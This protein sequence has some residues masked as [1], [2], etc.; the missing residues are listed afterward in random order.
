[1]SAKRRA[2]ARRR[3]LAWATGVL[4]VALWLGL[5]LALVGIITIQSATRPVEATKPVS[6]EVRA[7]DTALT[8]PV[9]LALDWSSPSPL[10]APTWSGVVQAVMVKSGQKVEN[11]TPLARIDG[12]ERRL[13]LTPAPF[14]LPV[15]YGDR[16]ADVSMLNEFLKSQGY[17]SSD[18]DAF[19]GATLE[20]L[21][22]YAADIG[23]A[24]AGSI[25]AFDPAWVVYLPSVSTVVNATLTVAAP[26][27]APGEEIVTLAPQVSSA[28]L[29][30]TATA[31][32]L[33][34]QEGTDEESETPSPNV[35][36]APGMTLMISGEVVELDE[37]RATVST[38]GLAVLNAT[39]P[40]NAKALLSALSADAAPGQWVVPSTAVMSDGNETCVVVG[41]GADRTVAVTLIAS[42]DGKAI[43]EGDLSTSNKVKV[44]APGIRASCK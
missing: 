27:P 43:V 19:R 40:A 33:I 12:I 16:G 30:D 5:P 36:A 23:V 28:A 24:S 32:R 7:N 25:E 31:Q 44:F 21:R 34:A 1:M 17:A 29:V 22:K 11:A 20:G 3:A 8:E 13:A 39:A 37:E 42:V 35:T 14:A 18:G 15:A 2:G 6:V 38:A 9:G 26:A 10:I 41:G 4:G